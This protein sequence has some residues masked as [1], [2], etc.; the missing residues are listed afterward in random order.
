[1]RNIL[2]LL[3]LLQLFGPAM[4]VEES[5]VVIGY[6][7]LP[8]SDLP[9]LQRLYTGRVTLISQQAATPVNLLPGDPLRQQFL[10]LVLSQ[11]EAQYTGYWLVRRYVGKGAP[12]LDLATVDEVI[13]YVLTTP[14]AVGYVPASRV[15]LGGNVIFKP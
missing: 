13:K 6:K 5:M 3:L 2:R 11:S 1:M 10:S 4:A 9:T 7:T 15:P 8:K 14:G 12:P